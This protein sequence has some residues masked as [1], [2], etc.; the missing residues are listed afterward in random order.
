MF[1]NPVTRSLQSIYIYILVWL[2]V[3]VFYFAL[4]YWGAGKSVIIAV[5]DSLI[6]NLIFAGLGLSFWYPAKFIQLDKYQF[7]RFLFTHL[8]GS[9]VSVIFWLFSGFI[10]INAVI[11]EQ[12]AYNN[13]F[14]ST[15][16]W[17]FLVGILF[18]FLV[19]SFYYI[20]IYYSE[21]QDK[22][23]RETE[24]KN[25][26]SEAE[27]RSLKF[28]INPHFI[29]NSLNSISSLTISN[30]A[31]ARKMLLKL[32]DFLRYTVSNNIKSMNPL[33]DEL[34]N[35]RL[36][37][38]IEKIRFEDRFDLIEEIDEEC[39]KYPVPNM[40]L[41]PLIENAIK[42]AVYEALDKVEIKIKCSKDDEFMNIGISNTL[43]KDSGSKG[44]GTGLKNISD[45][46]MLLYNRNDLFK[47]F[48]EEGIFKVNLY[49]P[50]SGDVLPGG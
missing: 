1:A 7:T 36:Y 3:S 35:I 23:R 39:R 48:K 4:I 45:R 33:E 42:H 15:V 6:N 27:L 19:I 30:P 12:E 9:I 40:I 21:Y 11:P 31:D 28:Q 49:I 29:F 47:I 43:E 34:K 2:F 20:I 50:L 16:A 18:Y 13:F 17:R 10:I 41:Q 37:L 25:L 46:M 26:I 44:T 22:A 38:D 14:Y 32:A 5:S 8:T 24:L